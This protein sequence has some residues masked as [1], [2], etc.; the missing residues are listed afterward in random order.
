MI[1]NNT[2]ILQNS[3]FI[4]NT[5]YKSSGGVLTVSIFNNISITNVIF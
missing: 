3:K 2:L 5:G 1:N 4:N